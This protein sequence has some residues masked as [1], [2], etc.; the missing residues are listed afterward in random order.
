MPEATPTYVT[1]ALA[2][3]SRG[4][5]SAHPPASQPRARH[6]LQ[7][8]RPHSLFPGPSRTRGRP[9]S[10]NPGGLHVHGGKRLQS[11]SPAQFHLLPG[12]KSYFPARLWTCGARAFLRVSAARLGK[13]RGWEAAPHSD[14]VTRCSGPQLCYSATSLVGGIL[15]NQ[16]QHYKSPK[17]LK[18]S[19]RDSRAGHSGKGEQLGRGLRRETIPP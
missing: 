6:S 5:P 13:D 18:I 7:G 2:P 10:A 17:L 12:C 8:Q 9:T 19:V 11:G 4:C 16:C 14:T 15:S 1:L 3:G